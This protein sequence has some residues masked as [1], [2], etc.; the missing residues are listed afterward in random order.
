MQVQSMTN[1][2]LDAAKR[3]NIESNYEEQP[4]PITSTSFNFD[5]DNEFGKNSEMNPST[6]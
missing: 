6:Q 1:L 2:S 5:K 3:V 4:I